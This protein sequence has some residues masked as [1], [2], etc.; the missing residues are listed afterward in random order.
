MVQS[1]VL[2]ESTIILAVERD[3]PNNSSKAKDRFLSRQPTLTVQKSPYIHLLVF[4]LLI[5]RNAH[6]ARKRTEV[7]A[8]LN[9]VSPDNGKLGIGSGHQS[10]LNIMMTVCDYSNYII[11]PAVK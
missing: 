11:K 7:R 4:F 2:D 5:R 3:S 6:M 1:V 9:P 8:R 10:P